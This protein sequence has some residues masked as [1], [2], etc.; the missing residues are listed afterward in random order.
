[1][2]TSQ[3]Y[4]QDVLGGGS[5][6]ARNMVDVCYA[7]TLILEQALQVELQVHSNVDHALG[8]VSLRLPD[9]HS[10]GV[11]VQVRQCPCELA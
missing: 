5:K 3:P 8:D 2:H 9:S 7:Q 4:P 10:T 1:M 11:V 6:Q